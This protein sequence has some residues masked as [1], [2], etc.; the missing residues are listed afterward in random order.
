[1]GRRWTDHSVEFWPVRFH[2]ASGTVQR[3]QDHF[4]LPEKEGVVC[5]LYCKKSPTCSDDRDP[6]RALDMRTLAFLSLTFC[7]FLNFPLAPQIQ[8]QLTLYVK[9]CLEQNRKAASS[10][11]ELEWGRR[12][13]ELGVFSP[14][15]FVTILN[16]CLVVQYGD[17]YY[18][19]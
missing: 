11:V 2:D 1:M 17:S 8:V 12:S 14:R 9:K 5:I 4:S 18:P 15:T 7:L 19:I 13:S 6:W 10:C 16:V 3:V